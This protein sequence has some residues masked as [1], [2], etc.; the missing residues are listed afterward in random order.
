MK[1]QINTDKNIEGHERLEAYF[2]G[3]LEKG[4][5]RFEDKITRVEVHFGDE[6]GEKFSLHDKKCVIEVRTAKL[7][8]VTVT[9]HADTLEKAFIGALAKA[10]KSLT[11]TFEK[12]KAY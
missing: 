4:L 10:K 8:P 6:N 3:E 9:D 5:K 11:T 7:Q 2:S 1:I 12:M